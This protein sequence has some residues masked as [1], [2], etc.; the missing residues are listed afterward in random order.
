MEA[1][2]KSQVP[3]RPIDSSAEQALASTINTRV[4]ARDGCAD[5]KQR[6][7]SSADVGNVDELDM[8]TGGA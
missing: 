6:S 7:D 1:Q 3:P 4:S 8:G 5:D 2:K